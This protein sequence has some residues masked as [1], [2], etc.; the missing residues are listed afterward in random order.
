V[1]LSSIK[2]TNKQ[3]MVNNQ[4]IIKHLLTSTQRKDK[5]ARNTQGK[6]EC[7]LKKRLMYLPNHKLTKHHHYLSNTIATE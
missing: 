7:K 5:F 1:A 3:Y 6:L 2:Q 4:Q